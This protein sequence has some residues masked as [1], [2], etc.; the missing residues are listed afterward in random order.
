MGLSS[1]KPKAQFDKTCC[2]EYSIKQ[3]HPIVIPHHHAST[4]YSKER[5]VRKSMVDHGRKQ[6]THEEDM[7]GKT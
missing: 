1:L 4:K 7:M 2:P 3:P 5:V 6:V